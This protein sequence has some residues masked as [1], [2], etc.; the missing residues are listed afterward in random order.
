MA[1]KGKPRKA[2]GTSLKH[3]G[4]KNNSKE[5]EKTQCE[6]PILCS[7]VIIDPP[8]ENHQSSI[9]CE[10]ECQSWL[11]KSCAGL[12]EQAFLY[13]S[14]SK[15]PYQCLHCTT[16]Q[17]KTEIT[18]LKVMV[19]ALSKEVSQLKSTLASKLPIQTQTQT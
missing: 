11:H 14:K 2:A 13:Y 18:Q 15:V 12:T 8:N 16:K 19:A 6:C 17:Q 1:E 7:K 9:F 4:R 5:D 3:S 10:G